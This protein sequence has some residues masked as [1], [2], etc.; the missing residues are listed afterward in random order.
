MYMFVY[1]GGGSKF[2]K[3]WLRGLCMTPR[4]KVV[5]RGKVSMHSEIFLHSKST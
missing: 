5:K 1:E 4:C 2:L 3:K